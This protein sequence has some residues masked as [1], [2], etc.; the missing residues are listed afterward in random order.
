MVVSGGVYADATEQTPDE[1]SM[2]KTA[3][4]AAATDTAVYAAQDA[5]V[6]VAGGRG[7]RLGTPAGGKAAVPLGGVTLLERTLSVVT[8]VVPRVVVV[9]A[10]GQ[11]L[12]R[13]A[14]STTARVE[15]VVD[16]QADAGPLAA[17]ADG[18]RQLADVAQPQR[19][20]LLACDMPL[21][22]PAVLRQLL[23]ACRPVSADAGG[24][25]RGQV[26]WVVP[27]VKGV[28]QVLCSA[29]AGANASMTEVVEA[30]LASGRRDLRGLLERLSWRS[31]TET[32]L[33]QADPQLDSFRDIDTAEDLVTIQSMTRSA[34]LTFSP[35]VERLLAAPDGMPRLPEL[36]PGRPVESHRQ[37]LA[38]LTVEQLFEGCA[39]RDASAARCCL[40]GLWLWNNFLDESH[41]IS[42]AIKTADGS[43]WHGI[44]HRREPDPGNAKYWFRLVGHHPVFAP[45]AAAA[46]ELAGDTDFAGASDSWSPAAFIDWS[47]SVAEGSTDEQKAREIAALE[48][49][50]LFAHCQRHASGGEV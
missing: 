7:R 2:S 23:A 29:L 43:Y 45:L 41:H 38:D 39:V 35:L 48:W 17:I 50:L 30:M 19:T 28:P 24:D 27:V 13:V 8:E 33:Q 36:G 12:P 14:R 47:S 42:Q 26:S 32:E 1:R 34:D 44:M 40:A 25:A 5:A 10:D 49:R 6:I 37:A 3:G 15:V 31:L 46:V 20:L 11:Q 4:D 16:S 22:K 9:A 18:L 21:L